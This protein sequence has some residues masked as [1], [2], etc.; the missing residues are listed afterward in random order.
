[1]TFKFTYKGKK[2]DIT[3]TNGLIID[4]EEAYGKPFDTMWHTSDSGNASIMAKAKLAIYVGILNNI[5][6]SEQDNSFSTSVQ[7][8]RNDDGF[9]LNAKEVNNNCANLFVSY[10]KQ[11]TEFLKLGKSGGKKK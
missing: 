1:M 8:L 3:L 6:L 2:Y 9:K 10:I 5:A 7:I 4:I 11:Q